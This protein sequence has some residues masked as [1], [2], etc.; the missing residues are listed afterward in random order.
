MTGLAQV[1]KPAE[2]QGRLATC[3]QAWGGAQI[4]AKGMGPGKWEKPAAARSV[5]SKQGQGQR[6][7]GVRFTAHSTD[8]ISGGQQAGA[9]G[10][11]YVNLQGRAGL[12]W[13]G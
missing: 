10:P 7:K 12:E 13:L 2:K 11:I 6:R 5:S 1:M 4:I 9:P 8:S 3:H